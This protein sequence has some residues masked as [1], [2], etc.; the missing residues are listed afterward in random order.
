MTRLVNNSTLPRNAD[1]GQDVIPGDHDGPYVRLNELLDNLCRRWLQLVLEDDEAD[2]FEVGF[3]LVPRHRLRLNPA[4]SLDVLGGA[5]ND[6]VSFVS[7][8]REK[9]FVV[10]REALRP[11]YLSHAFRCPFD[12]HIAALLAE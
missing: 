11:T 10:R 3:H 5:S 9:L 6:T 2:E 7:V 8:K 12:E 4:E 1:S